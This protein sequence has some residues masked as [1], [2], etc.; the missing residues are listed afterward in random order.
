MLYTFWSAFEV[1]EGAG[2]VR[3]IVNDERKLRTPIQE[4]WRFLRDEYGVKSPQWQRDGEDGAFFVDVN[5]TGVSVDRIER[6]IASAF[7]QAA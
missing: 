4:F 2:F 3:V 5:P 1:H 7:E 6:R